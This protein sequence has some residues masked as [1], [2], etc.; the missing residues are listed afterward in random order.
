MYEVCTTTV[1]LRLMSIYT[2]SEL[3]TII[4]D[5]TLV[6]HPSVAVTLL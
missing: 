1:Y 6:S 5:T 4:P 3:V 2:L